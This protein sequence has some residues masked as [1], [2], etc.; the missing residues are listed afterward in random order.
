MRT[1]IDEQGAL[2]AGA[3]RS[4]AKA[5]PSAY[6]TVVAALLVVAC[7]GTDSAE[8]SAGTT[9][10]G[11]TSTGGAGGSTGG[12]SS[13]GSSSGGSS[14]GGHGGGAVPAFEDDFDGT[15]VDTAVWQVATWTEHGGQTG[16]DRVYVEDGKL[17]LVFINDSSAGYLSSAI[18]SRDEFLYGRWE[19]RLRPAAVPGVL[20]SFYTIDW[21]DTAN[22]QS[23]SDGTKQEIDIEFLT[24]SF[25]AGTGQVHYAVH[26]DGLT[27]FGTNPDIDLGFNPSDDFHVWGF[28]IT[29][30]HIQWFV[31]GQVL[32]TYTYSE[33]P[34]TIDAPY[35]LKLNAWTSTS[36]VN[37][38]PATDVP[39]V[40]EIDWIRFFPR[41]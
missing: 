26:A 19:A 31:D 27:S 7:D 34:I 41:P 37:G 16:V 10:T 6:A 25:G 22:P 35:M 30:Q 1:G 9:S 2:V 18:Q 36:W 28:E 33:E 8:P 17:H 39:C 5:H 21:D 3:R 12:S 15:E 20:N 29:P 38:P 4:A 14:V 23:T 13:G 24:H 32:L 40:Y 11:G